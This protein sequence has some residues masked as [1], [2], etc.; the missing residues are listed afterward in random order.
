MWCFLGNRV[1]SV[2]VPKEQEYAMR[3][4]GIS[5]CFNLLKAA[6]CGKYVNFAVFKLYGD[7]TLNNVL[8]TTAKLIMSIPQSDIML[9]PKVSRAYYLLLECLA[10]GH[11]TFLSTLEPNVFLYILESISEGL[12]AL[13][14]FGK[15]VGFFV[16]ELTSFFL[17]FLRYNGMH[18]MLFHPG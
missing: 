17:C 10:E 2:D 6:L 9:Y 8:S 18:W 13:G 7:N 14:E 1:L 4:K 3:L 12:T 5:I 16:S 15:Y 11:I